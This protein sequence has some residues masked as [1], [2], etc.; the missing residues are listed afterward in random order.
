MDVDYG[1]AVGAGISIFLVVVKDQFINVKTLARYSETCEYAD[2]D[3][4]SNTK[5]END[6]KIFKVERSLYYVNC[7]SFQ[8]QLFKYYGLSPIEKLR[9]LD[10]QKLNNID[11]EENLNAKKKEDCL[12]DLIL[13][14]SAVNYIDTNGV[15][16]LMQIVEDFKKIDVK[17]YICESQGINVYLKF[18]IYLLILKV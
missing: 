16:L 3:F 15:N 18:N 7:D 5:P 6:V 14:F 8:N 17:V 4:I 9:Q 12:K 2:R 11:N 10:E 1:L 13:D